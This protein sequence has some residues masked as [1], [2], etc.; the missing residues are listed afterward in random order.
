MQGPVIGFTRVL[1]LI[2]AIAVFLFLFLENRPTGEKGT[3][4]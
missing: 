2:L 3:G 1:L 4:C